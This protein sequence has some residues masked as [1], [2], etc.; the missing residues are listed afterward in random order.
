MP[1][2]T[3][4]KCNGTMER[5]FIVD[6]TYGAT[7]PVRWFEGVVEISRWVGIKNL[8]KRRRFGLVT[9]RCSKCGFLESY[10]TEPSSL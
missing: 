6:S 3:C 7:F 4:P 9:D 5:G 10:A 2:S 1:V 8:R